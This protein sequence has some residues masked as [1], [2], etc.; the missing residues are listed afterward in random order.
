M[1]P[2]EQADNVPYVIYIALLMH[3]RNSPR[4]CSC[5]SA[6]AMNAGLLANGYVEVGAE[7]GRCKRTEFWGAVSDAARSSPMQRA[8]FDM[9]SGGADQPHRAQG[10]S[11]YTYVN[12]E[13]HEPNQS[14]PQL[15]KGVACDQF[16]GASV[17][18]GQNRQLA[19][20]SGIESRHRES[21]GTE[22]AWVLFEA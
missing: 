5:V 4:A 17:G 22:A 13:L 3:V 2:P 20:P 16:R 7:G 9:I 6:G 10:Y 1:Q 8:P 15:V 12:P 18:R 11:E 14:Q 19:K 21:G